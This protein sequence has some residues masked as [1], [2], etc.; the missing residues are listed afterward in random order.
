MIRKEAEVVN[1][2]GLHARPA[3][4]FVS[5]ATKYSSKIMIEKDGKK[6]NGKSIMGLLTLAIGK[7]SVIAIEA[8]GDDEEK[9]VNELAEL[10]KSGL[11]EE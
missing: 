4:I 5:A 7:G 1:N 8:E 6:V 11:G 9:A 10:I 2:S 3:S